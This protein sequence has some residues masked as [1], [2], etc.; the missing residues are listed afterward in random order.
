MGMTEKEINKGGYR[1]PV[2]GGEG[3]IAYDDTGE[4]QPAEALSTGRLE[5]VLQKLSGEGESTELFMEADAT[6]AHADDADGGAEEAELDLSAGED[7]KASDP[8]RLYLR[9]M[10][11]VPHVPQPA[12]CSSRRRLREPDAPLS[13][14]A[15]CHPRSR[16][17]L[18]ASSGRG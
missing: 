12:G 11:R 2:L 16:R 15:G 6:D 3:F 4:E 14:R 10:G 18:R 5:D 1:P 13:W 9:Q 17:R 8:V 7:D